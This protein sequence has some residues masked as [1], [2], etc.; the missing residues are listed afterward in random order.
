MTV[1][2]VVGNC[3][4]E[5]TRR[6]L[7][8]TG[9]FES[10]RIRPIHEIERGDLGW[11]TELLARTDVLVTQPIRDDYRG[12]PVGTRQM[13][14]HL[15]R[16]A[17]HVVVPVL[18]FDG[19]MPYTAIIRNPADTSEN[20]PV[21]PYHDLRILAAA[22]RGLDAPVDVAPPA[23]AL[24]RAAAMSVAQIRTREQAHGA[25]TVS[26]YLETNPV[27]HTINHPDNATL[28]VLAERVL[29]ALGVDAAPELPDYEMLG[30]VDAPVNAASAAALGVDPAVAAART[31]WTD[32]TLGPIDHGLIVREQLEYYRERPGLVAHGLTRHADRLRNLGL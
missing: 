21:V 20:P 32:R 27:W 6:L 17:Q 9:R 10:E 5:S 15:P 18:R 23:E 29:E 14:G 25:V 1:L 30:Q 13:L 19:L 28:G 31:Q 26:D 4:A 8:S 3:Q 7:M 12:V 24:R 16:G 22:A 2:T 11:F